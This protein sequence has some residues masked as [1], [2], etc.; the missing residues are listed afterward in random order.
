LTFDVEI[1]DMG[2]ALAF[3][4]PFDPKEAFG[5]VRAPVRV[6]INGFEFRT[7][8]GAM[9]GRYLIGL[10]KQVR[11]G[12]GVDPGDRVSV[13]VVPDEEP[14][15]VEVPDD[16]SAA[17]DPA[18]RAFFDSL[19]YTHRK[20]YV[21]WIEEAKRAE[22]REARVAKAAAMLRDRIRHP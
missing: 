9:S 17:L 16:L 19:S 11:V 18:V 6:T 13:E 15:T 3:D 10:N 4:L 12:A 21:R 22:T 1:V 7:T 14:R 20:E 5:K 2:R 8:V